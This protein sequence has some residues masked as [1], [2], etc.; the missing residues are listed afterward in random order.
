[1]NYNEY[2]E[3]RH[4]QLAGEKGLSSRDEVYG[5]ASFTQKYDDP[6]LP[7]LYEKANIFPRSKILVIGTGSGADSC[8]LAQKGYAVTIFV[9]RKQE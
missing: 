8:W 9:M 4:Y 2:V 3:N 5:G 1:M 7:T 6:E